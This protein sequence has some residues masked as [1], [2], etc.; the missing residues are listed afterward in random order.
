M[1]PMKWRTLLNTQPPILTSMSLAQLFRHRA[2]RCL[3]LILSAIAVGTLHAQP[4]VN[5]NFNQS[6]G[7]YEPIASGTILFNGS[8]DDAVSGPITV[9]AFIYNEVSYTQI[10]VSTNGFITFGSAP[11]A[12][13]YTP[14]SSAEGYAGCV[15][16]FGA[17]LASAATGTTHIRWR[18]LG[19]QIVV[20]W[21]NVRRAGESETFS[22]QARLNRYTGMIRFIYGPINSG[23][24]IST[25]NFPQVGLRGASND[26]PSVADTS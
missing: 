22:F 3:V 11:S 13:N 19:Y 23:P 12:T 20:Q 21:T 14:L 4:V 2:I 9:P 25:A 17:N 10:W 26:P 5:Y 16:P 18:T 6:P 7:T 1:V 15:S 8:F 24:S